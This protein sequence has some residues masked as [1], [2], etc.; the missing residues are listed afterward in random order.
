MIWT[1]W[2]Q[3]RGLFVAFV[4]V[5]L[6]FVVVMLFTGLHEQSLWNH[7]MARP[8]RGGSINPGRNANFC[9]NLGSG[10][11]VAERIDPFVASIGL[12]LGPL[13]GSVLGVSAVAREVERRT[14]RLAWT[15]SGSRSQWLASKYLV[16]VALLV[17]ILLP[18]CLMMSW[19][20]SAAH[21]GARVTPKAFPIAGFMSLVYGVFAFV[22]VVALGIFIR[23]AGWTIAVGLVIVGVVFFAVELYVQPRLVSPSLATASSVQVTQGST[24]GFYSYG[25]VPAN[26]W[27][28]DGGYMP[29][30]VKRTPSTSTLTFFT[31]KMNRCM[32]T[33][34][35]NAQNG[36]AYCER[37]LGMSYVELYVP[38]SA[39]WKLQLLE[40]SMYLAAALL[41][42][43]VGFVAVRRILA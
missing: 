35:G 2:R 17:T 6:V 19:W 11:S 26:A 1:S 40:G 8:C 9:G 10:I 4:V 3:Q 39:F 21:Y 36:Q 7:Y 33:P 16:N 14:T 18:T 27:F 28:L 23:R 31:D 34:P 42:T 13:V 20:N 5:T 12:V 41:L 30:N 24:S 32:S 29:T 43:G 22:L 38:D 15:Q 25:G 37:L